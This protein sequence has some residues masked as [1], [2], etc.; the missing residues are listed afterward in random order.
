MTKK[1]SLPFLESR[2]LGIYALLSVYIG[3]GKTTGKRKLKHSLNK[4]CTRELWERDRSHH[5]TPLT[6]C[7]Y[8]LV[9]RRLS[10]SLPLSPPLSLSLSGWKCARKGRREGAACTLPMVSYGASQVT[11]V[12]RSPLRCEKWSAWGGGWCD[13]IA[14]RMRVIM[15]LTDSQNTIIHHKKE[16]VYMLSIKNILQ[17]FI[18]LIHRTFFIKSGHTIQVIWV[19]FLY[20]C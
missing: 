9:P 17:Q 14:G 2:R 4:R 12:S 15:F 7:G 6:K 13:Y 20:A 18:P 8:C 1:T 10:L 3:S 11:R 5:Q 16:K 19:K